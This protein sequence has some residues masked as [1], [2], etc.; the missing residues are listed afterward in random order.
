[1][2]ATDGSNKNTD[3]KVGVLFGAGEEIRTLDVD[4]GK[5]DRKGVFTVVPTSWTGRTNTVLDLFGHPSGAASGATKT[6]ATG[7]SGG[8]LPAIFVNSDDSQHF[9]I[10]PLTP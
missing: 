9:Q 10:E 6:R 2:P 8:R 7:L 4:L 3:Q 5:A 1:M